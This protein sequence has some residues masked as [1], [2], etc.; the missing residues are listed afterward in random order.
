MEKTKRKNLM[1]EYEKIQKQYKK[2]SIKNDHPNKSNEFIP[3]V[4]RTLTPRKYPKKKYT[5]VDKIPRRGVNS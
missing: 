5:I 2:F 4:E 1:K 3:R